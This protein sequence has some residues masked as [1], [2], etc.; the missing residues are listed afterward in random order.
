[1][2]VYVLQ[3]YLSY[4]TGVDITGTAGILRQQQGGALLSEP[5]L[6]NGEGRLLLALQLLHLGFNLHPGILPLRCLLPPFCVLVIGN[7][8]KRRH[9]CF[10]LKP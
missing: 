2:A 3:Q 5:S 7:G 8:C 4:K 1:M 10:L 6:V 9:A